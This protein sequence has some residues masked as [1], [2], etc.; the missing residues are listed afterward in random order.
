MR[1]GKQR[2]TEAALAALY[3]RAERREQD[4]TPVQLLLE[5]YQS[6]LAHL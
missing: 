3:L 5:L 6:E 1:L 4:E 2:P